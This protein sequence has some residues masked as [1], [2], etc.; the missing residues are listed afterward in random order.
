[1]RD[2]RSL[3]YTLAFCIIQCSGHSLVAIF[4]EEC[5]DDTTTYGEK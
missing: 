1:M 3:Q 4:C 2:K 5:Y